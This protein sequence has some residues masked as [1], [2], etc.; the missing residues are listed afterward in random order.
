MV[1]ILTQNPRGNCF[2]SKLATKLGKT[3]K[4]SVTD[5]IQ[6]DCLLHFTGL[7]LLTSSGEVWKSFQY[8]ESNSRWGRAGGRGVLDVILFNICSLNISLCE[9]VN[10]IHFAIHDNDILIFI[11]SIFA[12]VYLL[13]LSLLWKPSNL[14]FPQMPEKHT[15]LL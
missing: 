11:F 6:E 13:Y 14:F 4:G 3:W 2:L 10:W 15:I 9:V 1:N 12:A 5:C 8:S 7:L